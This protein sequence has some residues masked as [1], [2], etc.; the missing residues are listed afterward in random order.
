MITNFKKIND[1][2]IGKIFEKLSI[3]ELLKIS[4]IIEEILINK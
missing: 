1:E 4:E 3:D 2:D